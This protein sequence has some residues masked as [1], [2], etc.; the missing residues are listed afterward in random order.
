MIIGG[1][2]LLAARVEKCSAVRRV[3][4]VNRC[5]WMIYMLSD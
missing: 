2:G 3:K 4:E 5:W 1:M